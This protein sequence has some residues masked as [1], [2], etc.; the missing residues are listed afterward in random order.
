MGGCVI[1]PDSPAYVCLKCGERFGLANIPKAWGELC[2]AY[3]DYFGEQPPLFEL[4]D[5]EERLTKALRTGRPVQPPRLRGKRG[6][7]DPLID[8]AT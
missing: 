3:A 5:P 1:E 8:A 6:Q 7:P 2:K 4:P